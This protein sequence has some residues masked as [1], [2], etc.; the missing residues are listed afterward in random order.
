MNVLNIL[1]SREKKNI[2][3]LLEGQ[4]GCKGV[5]EYEFFMNS[6]NRIFLLSKDAGKIDMEELRVNSLGMYFGEIND[7]ELR[8][9]IEGSQL[10]G[11]LAKKN[12]LELD[13]EQAA[14]WMAGEDFEVETGLKGFALIKNR[15]DFM[16]CGKIAGKKL[17]NHV[18][19]ERRA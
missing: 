2:G 7:R 13:D 15:E 14:M 18:P 6:K 3:R 5:L 17:L 4:F 16:G 11:P 1:N 8:L 10:I 19:K 12:V 9:S